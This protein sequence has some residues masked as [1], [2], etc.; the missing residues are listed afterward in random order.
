MYM[1]NPR[2]DMSNKITFIDIVG[3]YGPFIIILL[4]IYEFF[5][6]K[7]YLY[8]Y[9]L[10]IFVNSTINSILKNIFQIPRQTKQVFFSKYENF[11]G[12]NAYGMPSGHAQSIAFSSTFLYLGQVNSYVLILTLFISCL[13]LIQRY[14]YRRHTLIELCV[15]L[16]LGTSIGII[17]YN[18][19]TYYLETQT[20]SNED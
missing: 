15:G 17:A 6:R 9:L 8:V 10:L 4:S 19:T 13:T 1:T 20:Q 16:F 14:K 5:Y 2:F 12:V 7:V 18:V 11:E 3:H